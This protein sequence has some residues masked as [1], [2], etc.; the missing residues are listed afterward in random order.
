MSKTMAVHVRYKF[1]Y[2]YL[3]SSLKQEREM[4]KFCVVWRRRTTTTNFSYSHL[5][6]NAAI[7]YLT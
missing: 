2:I 1:L 3:P 5:E 6:L 7:V 4:T